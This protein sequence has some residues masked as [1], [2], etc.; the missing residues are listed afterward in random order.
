MIDPQAASALAFDSV[1][2]NVEH[3]VALRSLG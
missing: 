1:T 3:R 2:F